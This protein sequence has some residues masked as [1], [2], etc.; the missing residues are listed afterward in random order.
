MTLF[1]LG[2]YTIVILIEIVKKQGG[3]F[4]ELI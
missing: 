4:F 2:I 3:V 1:S